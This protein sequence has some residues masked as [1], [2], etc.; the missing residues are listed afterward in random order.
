MKKVHYVYKITNKLNGKEYIGIHSTDDINDGYMGSSKILAEDIKVFGYINFVKAILRVFNNRPDALDFEKELVTKEY[1]SRENTYNLTVGGNSCKS[2]FD[3]ISAKDKAGNKL[4]VHKDDPRWLN[5]ELVGVRKGLKESSEKKKQKSEAIKGR[6]WVHKNG[7]CIRIWK[8]QIKDH[9][10]NGWVQGRIINHRRPHSQETKDKIS[11]SNM[12][13][14]ASE[15]HRQKAREISKDRVWI[16][17]GQ[18]SKFVKKDIF[19]SSLQNNG[20]VLGRM[21]FKYNN[22]F[23]GNP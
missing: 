20:W 17:D 22:G 1:V 5:G 4:L 11:K 23:R 21:R 15:Q 8:E 7:S 18:K 16:N 12:G 2:G 9:L 19:E 10:L 13:K 14:Q 6:V 3:I